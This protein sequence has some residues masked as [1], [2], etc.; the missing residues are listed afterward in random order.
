MIT[1]I[2]ILTATAHDMFSAKI[3]NKYNAGTAIKRIYFQWA[4]FES[5]E[6]K[7]YIHGTVS[8]IISIRRNTIFWGKFSALS[9]T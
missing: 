1:S 6:T 5:S 8:S 2:L 7:H 3:N 4:S 9:K